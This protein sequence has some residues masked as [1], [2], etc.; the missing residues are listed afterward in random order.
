VKFKDIELV[1]IPFRVTV[2]ARSLAEGNVEIVSRA[3]G[4]K[5]LVP[6]GEAVEYVRKLVL[7]AS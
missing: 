2:G 7:D 3:T 1:G 5:A 6:I 4:E